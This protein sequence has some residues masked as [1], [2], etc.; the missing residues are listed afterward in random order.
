MIGFK[1]AATAA[2]LLMGLWLVISAVNYLLENG[3]PIK[4]EAYYIGVTV[5]ISLVILGG[6]I[7]GIWWL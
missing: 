6:M 4:Y 3:I 1:I 7:Y 2:M 5:P